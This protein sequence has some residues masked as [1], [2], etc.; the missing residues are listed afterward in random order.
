MN[1]VTVPPH[2]PVPAKVLIIGE[3]PTVDDE[4]RMRLFTGQAGDEFHKMLHE[5]GFIT[6]DIR[7]TTLLASRPYN[8]Q[9]RYAW[10][11]EPR[12]AKICMPGIKKDPSGLFYTEEFSASCWRVW[13]QIEACNPNVII[14]L[15]DAVLWAITGEI[16]IS[17]WRGSL[18]NTKL[19]ANGKSVKV[20]PTFSPAQ[21]MK[22]WEWRFFAVRDL[23]RAKEASKSPEYVMPENNLLIRQ[24]YFDTM[25]L[26]RTTMVHVARSTS[27][28]PICMDIETIGRHIACIGVAWSK[29]D[30]ICIPFMDEHYTHFYTAGEEAD[31]IWQIRELALHPNVKLIW[32]NGSYDTQHIVR[33][34]GFRPR[35]DFDTM[36]AQHIVFPGIPKDLGFL[37]SMYC[38][39][40]VY[41]KDELTDYKVLPKDLD[42]FWYYACKD[43]INTFEVAD[44]L[45]KLVS[46]MGFDE[47][48]AFLHRLNFHVIS[49]MIRGVNIDTIEKTRLSDNLAYELDKRQAEINYLTSSDLNISSPPQMKELFYDSL[50]MQP[51]L[52]KKTH[53]PT[54]DDSALLMFG[55]REPI[56][57]PLVDLISET[58]SIGVFLR[59]FV[60]MPLDTDKRMRCSFNVAGTETYRFSSSKNAFGSGGNL[61][62]IPSGTEEEEHLEGA[63]Q[64]IFPNLRRMF[65]PDYKMVMFDVDLAG[66]DAQVVAWEAHDDD[67]K[68]KFRSGQKIH[69]LNAKDIYGRDAGPD[70]TRKPYYKLAKMGCHLSNYGG[71]AR[72]LSKA[73]GMTI[74]EAEAFQKRWFQMHPGIKRWHTEVEH[75]LMTTRSVRNQFGFR[76]FYFD[77]IQGLLP[78]ALAWLPQSTIA[79]VINHGLCNIAE[80]NTSMELLLQV[81]DSLVGQFPDTDRYLNLPKL[82]D[83]LTV[84]IPYDDPLIIGTSLDISTKSWG[85]LV[86]FKWADIDTI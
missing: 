52:H 48:L 20:I 74:H 63:T 79:I 5:A 6:A 9:M 32:Q 31:L 66:A 4:R 7:F 44:V 69:A 73:L 33:S 40:Y 72:T 23:E 78:Q 39:H 25:G 10:T 28:V 80:S 60:R 49:M 64:F 59:T 57:K 55:L 47:Q 76:R 58:R 36:L 34:W 54:T 81:H 1:R 38:E 65:K 14:T 50:K 35:I 29:R 13:E 18:L 27:P 22:L 21:V 56:L 84:T 61:Q 82:R 12:E 19:F 45:Q 41:W 75:S 3:F 83:C 11:K 15:G 24:N 70:G 53:Q 30:A 8:S 71:Q 86:S 37:A 77:R 51:V 85:D 26:L 46:R 16:S 43:V 68:E 42:K 62:N 2:G 67:L 17:K